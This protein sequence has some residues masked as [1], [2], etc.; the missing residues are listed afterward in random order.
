MNRP[1]KEVVQLNLH[2]FSTY[3]NSE[4]VSTY[5][6][7]LLGRIQLKG[8]GWIQLFLLVSRIHDSHLHHHLLNTQDYISAHGYIR[9]CFPL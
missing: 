3:Y 8:Q 7:W 4:S 2:R 6:T 9:I 5:P 1:K